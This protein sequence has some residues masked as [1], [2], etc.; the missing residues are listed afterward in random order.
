MVGTECSLTNFVTPLMPHS[1]EIVNP[2]IMII[3]KAGAD[4]GLNI[5]DKGAN[6]KSGTDLLFGQVFPKTA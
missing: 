6:T 2:V 3:S 5:S 1:L 4:P